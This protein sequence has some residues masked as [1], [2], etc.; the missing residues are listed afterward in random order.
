MI[1]TNARK[2]GI[3]LRHALTADARRPGRSRGL[4]DARY[5]SPVKQEVGFCTSADGTRLGFAI[6]GVGRPIVR[7]AMAH[8]AR[9]RLGEPGLAALAGGV[10]LFP[11]ADP[12]R[13]AGMRV[14]RGGV[15]RPV[16]GETGSRIL[17]PSRSPWR[18]PRSIRSA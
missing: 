9:V 10:E 11:Y 17:R 16:F 1:C 15:R 18:T 2:A 4:S 13:R 6:H 14:L 8:A 5:G 12:L 3:G 7:V